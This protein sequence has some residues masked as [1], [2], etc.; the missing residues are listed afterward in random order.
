MGKAG[1]ECE[2]WK[3]P[4]EHH[5]LENLTRSRLGLVYAASDIAMVFHLPQY[6]TT[7]ALYLH[8]PEDKSHVSWS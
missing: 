5:W 3:L 6:K 1:V 7:S 8:K 4:A 2:F